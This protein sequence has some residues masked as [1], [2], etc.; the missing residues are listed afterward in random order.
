[1]S[2]IGRKLIALKEGVVVT[3]SGD[4]IKVE[5]K[6]KVVT[7][8]LLPSVSFEIKDKQIMVD[9]KDDSKQ[10]RANWGTVRALLQNAVL[11]VTQDFSKVLELEG[12]GFKVALE[13]KNVVMNLG[14]SHPVKYEPPQGITVKVEKNIITISGSDK[15]LV[16]ATA[17]KIRQFKKPEPYK[18]KGIHYKGEV[19]RRKAG[20]KVGATTGAAA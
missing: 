9:S 3:Q 6:G 16:G 10:G 8:P 17:A 14:F 18:G 19:I 13:G 4:T 5:N 1:M 12:I 11:G 20:K 15:G 7:V 2:K